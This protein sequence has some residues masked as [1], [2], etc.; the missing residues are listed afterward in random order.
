MYFLYLDWLRNSV[1][2]MRFINVFIAD[3]LPEAYA[4]RGFRAFQPC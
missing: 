1:F 4:P 2:F 3:A